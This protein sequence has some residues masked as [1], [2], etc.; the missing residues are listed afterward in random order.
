M[1]RPATTLPAGIVQQPTECWELLYRDRNGMPWDDGE[2]SPHFATEADADGFIT[3]NEALHDVVTAC[4]RNEGCWTA[5]AA[6]GRQFHNDPAADVLAA[7][8]SLTV[9]AA[10]S[11]AEH[12]PTPADALEGVLDTGWRITDGALRCDDCPTCNPEEDP[13]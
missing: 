5:I 9:L 13:R 3:A 2:H 10:G 7:V 12:W 4:P 11:P 1:T 6:C 8:F